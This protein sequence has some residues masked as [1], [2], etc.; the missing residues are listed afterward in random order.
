MDRVDKIL[1][2]I[3]QQPQSLEDDD[4]HESVKQKEEQTPLIESVTPE[5]TN[6]QTQQPL[7]TSIN[8]D[9]GKEYSNTMR[10]LNK[11]KDFP[12][13]VRINNKPIVFN[14]QSTLLQYKEDIRVKRRQYNKDQRAKR[15]E[16]SKMDFTKL[17]TL[18]D[19]DG[20]VEEG[21]ALY[22]RKQIDAIK[23]DGKIYRVPKTN[24]KDTKK[25]FKDISKNKESLKKLVKSQ[26][27]EFNDVVN[28]S[29]NEQHTRDIYNMHASNDI[30]EDNTFTREQFFKYM[31]KLM[32]EHEQATQQ[33]QM[34]YGLN[35]NLLK[36]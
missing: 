19:S 36:H 25:I 16:S 18:D 10:K 8:V 4:V 26:P 23:K 21:P 15:I 22:K 34:P 2:F 33:K 27:D 35:P 12:A 24:S 6:E 13:I 1:N 30:N 31:E 11:I 29:I 7:I 9:D 14:D 3:D 28:E 32:N 17:Q 20:Y 5:A